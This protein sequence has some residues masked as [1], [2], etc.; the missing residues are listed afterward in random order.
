MMTA[1]RQFASYLK[2]KGVDIDDDTLYEFIAMERMQ[3]ILAYM[4][5]YDPKISN[6]D[7]HA[8]IKE[9]EHYYWLKYKKP[10]EPII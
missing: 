3:I 5:H 1:V 7:F 10:Y 6:D 9:G 8:L 2:T 4:G